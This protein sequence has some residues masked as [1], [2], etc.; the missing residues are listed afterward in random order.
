MWYGDLSFFYQTFTAIGWKNNSLT[1]IFCFVNVFGTDVLFREDLI[2][3][4]Y[5]LLQDKS[6][7]NI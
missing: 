2:Q 5:T 1:F 3:K 7:N 4:D 6:Q